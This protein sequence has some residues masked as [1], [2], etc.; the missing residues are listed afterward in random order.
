MLR[1]LE[2]RYAI[3][4]CVKL[5]KTFTETQDLLKQAYGDEVL[6]RA[7]IHAWH[8]AFKDGREDLE[9]EQRSGRPSTSKTDEDVDRVREFLNI[10]RRSSLREISEELN[11]TYY[12]VQQ[13]VTGTLAMRKVCA[14]M[15]PKVL[16]DEQKESRVRL[17]REV[18]ES[19]GQ[20]NILDKTITGDETWCFEYDP[21]TK[22]QSA[23]WHTSTSPRPK[24]ARMSKSKVKTMLIVFFDCRGIVHK[25]FVPPRTT[26]NAA[27]YKEVLVRLR[28]R[29]ARCR[30]QLVG[31]W[32]LHH[33]N[34]PAHTAFL[35]T[36]YL[37]KKGIAV[38]PHPPTAQTCHHQTSFCFRSSKKS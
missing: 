38:L 10:D 32:A 16:T 9:D 7:R 11:L 36:S 27:F 20:E 30:P 22:A 5:N 37:A 13:I 31:E 17:S 26:V 21:E 12:S 2:Q 23:E 24:K 34:A 6:S 1:S 33:D 25:E 14:K 8:K 28:N 4:F 18:L 3:K 29:V 19:D 35:C 15:V